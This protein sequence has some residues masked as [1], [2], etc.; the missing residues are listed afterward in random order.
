VLLVDDHCAPMVADLRARSRSL[1]TRIHL[2]DNPTPAGKLPYEALIERHSTV[3]DARRGGKDLAGGF[4]A[5]RTTGVPKSVMLSRTRSTS[6]S[7][8]WTDPFGRSSSNP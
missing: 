8:C 6:S 7:G 2:G 1:A 5:G 4:Y 3:T